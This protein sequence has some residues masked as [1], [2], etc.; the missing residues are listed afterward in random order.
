MKGLSRHVCLEKEKETVQ[1]G[2][3]SGHEEGAW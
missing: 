3:S 1:S 2:L